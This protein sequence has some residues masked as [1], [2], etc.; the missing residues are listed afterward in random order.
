M[1]AG[2][3]E[4]GFRLGDWLVEPR[5][6]RISGNGS[7]H[8]LADH[9]V[10]ILQVLAERHGE[11]VERQA[12]RERAWPD[13]PS[14]DDMLRASMRELRRLLGD[15]PK[16]PRYIVRVAQRGYALIAHFEPLGNPTLAQAAVTPGALVIQS[17][18]L[19][20]LPLFFSEMRRRN[21]F[22]VL[23]AYLVGMWVMLQVAQTT[24]QPLNFPDWWLTAL[25]I[26]AV[27][28]IPIVGMLAW[29]YEITPAGI[30][31]DA[32]STARVALPKA[33][34]AVA[35]WLVAGVALMMGVTGF[36][37]WKTIADSK[38][39]VPVEVPPSEPAPASVAVLP[40]VDMTPGG[41]N[42]YLGDGFA[43]EIS[44]QLAQV[45]GL[46][47]A[48]RTSAFEFK[49]KSLDVRKIGDA[50]GV[51]HVLEG[52]VRRDG[53]KLR[54]TVQLIDAKNGYHVWAGSYDKDWSDVIAIQDSISR[55]IAQKLAVVLTPE[56]ERKLKR[57]DVANLAAY[58]T[59]LS[60]VSVLHKS[61]DLSQLNR[62]GT[63]F[64]EALRLDP[65]FSRA[66]AGLC[67]VGT[68]RYERTQDAREIAEAEDACR[69]ALELDPSR[70]ETEMA[71]ANLYITGG[72]SEQAE[73]IFRGLLKRRPQDADV[74]IG[75]AIA[76]EGQGRRD[77][78]EN[79]YRLAVETEPGY[80]GTHKALGNF[81]FRAGRAEEAIA[82]YRRS[83]E[84]APGSA[85]AHS[86][87][88]A[89]LMLD[90]R[91]EEAAA[92]FEMSLAIEPSRAAHSNLGTLYFYL[93]R[94]P[95][96]A[97]EYEKAKV[98]ASSDH[99]LVGSLADALW[100]IE[101]RRPE[102]V[103]MY[104]RAAELAQQ[105]LKI[106]PSDAATWAQLAYFCGRAADPKCSARAEARALGLAA[107]DMYVYYFLALAAA[108]RGD[109]A[110][111]V[112][113]IEQA[114]RLG[115]PRKLLEADPVLKKLLPGKKA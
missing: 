72:R 112:A 25:T 86:N 16:E 106:N 60:G 54:V 82:A 32:G 29:S 2:D 23:G 107:E 18:L 114:R 85:S 50:L 21:V 24:F 69:K 9:Q 26:L 8:V 67:E 4:R 104:R 102:A 36:A 57:D 34:R 103:G 1:D 10:R 35:P 49:D 98:I 91:F 65:S 13:R 89:A 88:G 78:A 30:E 101:G 48:A 27:I 42:E 46:R 5:R 59:Y 19:G 7:T 94:F 95:D 11:I 81:M 70:D 58:E 74:R 52:S 87:L 47:V 105:A 51:H 76:L 111:S 41:G 80:A 20:R 28:G 66:Y 100:L 61:S 44:A 62:A 12:L 45:P 3:L 38:V 75:L 79:E 56:S 39:G 6:G 37:W 43:E 77:E 22:K 96:A 115:Y 97:L 68:R 108:D 63:L 73:A 99:T 53:D 109:V 17:P 33:R 40:L 113:S 71:L 110:A 92:S 64:Q 93:G 90:N 83:V 15:S 84:L 55:A 31:L 14:S